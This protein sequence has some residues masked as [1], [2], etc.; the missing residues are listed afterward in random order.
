MSKTVNTE[1]K[2]TENSDHPT[3]LQEISE[4]F[5]TISNN[6]INS[7]PMKGTI[8]ANIKDANPVRRISY[9]ACFNSLISFTSKGRASAFSLT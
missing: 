6:K 5:V 1:S 8:D 7:F 3:E 4:T 9:V 2:N